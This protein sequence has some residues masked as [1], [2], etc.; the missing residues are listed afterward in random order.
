MT[1]V[2]AAMVALSM[3]RLRAMNARVVR[4]QRPQRT[5]SVSKARSP[6]A[7][8][9]SVRRCIWAFSE[10][11]FWFCSYSSQLMYQGGDP[12]TGRSRRSSA[13]N[14]QWSC[15]AA[16]VDDARALGCAAEHIAV[17]IDRMRED[18]RYR[19]VGRRSGPSA[20]RRSVPVHTFDDWDDPPPG[21]IEANLVAT[22]G[23]SLGA[24]SSRPWC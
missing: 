1:V 21:F 2:A 4:P 15:G 9:R 5:D 18:L 14:V 23:R 24:A 10:I 20:I 17:S 11:S 12:A 3:A 8:L 13:S 16:P 19:V 6:R 7:D 22:V